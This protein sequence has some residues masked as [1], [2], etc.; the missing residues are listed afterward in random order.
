MP[1]TVYKGHHRIF[2]YVDDTCRTLANIVDNF[3]PGEVY[4]LGGKEDWIVDIKYVS[5]LILKHLG[6]DDKLVTY[7]EAEPFT[8]RT[9]QVDFSKIRRDL[10]HE[11]AVPIEDGI[12]HY[13]EWMRKMYG[14]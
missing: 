10:K 8:T 1:Y 2:D 4:N 12:P 6:K 3:I 13:I 14:K 5:D 9:K 7:K 11:P